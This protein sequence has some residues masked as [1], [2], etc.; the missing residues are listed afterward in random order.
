M[1]TVQKSKMHTVEKGKMH[2][3]VKSEMQQHSGEMENA[4]FI[5]SQIKQYVQVTAHVTNVKCK[6]GQKG[7]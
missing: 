7:V 4:V 5:T 3:V 2:T 1:H 6:T